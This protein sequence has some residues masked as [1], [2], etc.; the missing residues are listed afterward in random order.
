MPQI[1]PLRVVEPPKPKRKPKIAATP[2]LQVER[3]LRFSVNQSLLEGSVIQRMKR[4]LA[5]PTVGHRGKS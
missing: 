5:C 1:A 4:A 3:T 2:P